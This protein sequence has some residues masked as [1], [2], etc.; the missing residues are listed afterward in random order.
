MGYVGSKPF[1]IALVVAAVVLLSGVGAYSLTRA[2]FGVRTEPGCTAPSF[3]RGH[4]VAPSAAQDGTA[5]GQP[6][7]VVTFDL[8]AAANGSAGFLQA[9]TIVGDV[10]VVPS[11]DD[12]PHVVFTITA[13]TADAV[14]GTEVKM[15]LADEDGALRLGAWQSTVGQSVSLF[16]QNSASADVRIELP[17]TGPLDARVDTTVGDVRLERLLVGN[18]TVD[19]T[20]GDVTLAD[21]D[22]TGNVT[23][24]STTGDQ[25]ARFSS[26]QTGN[27]SFSSTTGDVTLHLPTRVDVGYDV[28]ADTSTGDA[29]V[30]VGSTE[31][32]ERG[33][34]NVGSH[35]HARSTGYAARPTR[36]VVTAE[37]TTG[38]ISVTAR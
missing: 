35:V 9:C 32:N 5:N 19:S 23:S 2:S 12:R 29:G 34:G 30:D 27:L 26:V 24:S 36:V 13:R 28:T 10:T 22:L 17:A 15:A 20:T 37:T 31:V 11:A 1:V 38:D 21:I 3:A 25:S 6:A 4:E 33:E 18:L 14:R 16:G 7:R 8:P